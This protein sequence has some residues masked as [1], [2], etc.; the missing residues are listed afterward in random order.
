M[1]TESVKSVLCHSS[2]P[3]KTAV[4]IIDEITALE[5]RFPILRYITQGM[6]KDLVRICVSFMNDLGTLS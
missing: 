4:V 2:N 6:R 1:A 5:G 3:I